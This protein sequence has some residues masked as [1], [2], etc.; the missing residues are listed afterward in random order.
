MKAFLYFYGDISIHNLI[1]L[2]SIMMDNKDKMPATP[3]SVWEIIRELSLSI[4]ESRAELAESSAKF[5]R[6]L[7][8]SSA[9]FDR[10]LAESHAKWNLEM[11]DLKEM[12]GGT[13]NSN[14]M[15]A[16]EYFFNSI[17]RGDK[18]LFGEKFD[19]CYSSLKRYNRN[20]RKKSEH[21]VLLVNGKSVAIVEIK[22]KARK[23]DI[24]KIINKIPDFRSLYPQYRSH[25]IYLGLAAM[26]FENGVEIESIN[27]GLAIIKQVGDTVVIHDEHLKTF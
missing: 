19:E 8:E 7:A 6:E 12:I 1:I 3:E 26:S 14:G 25:R 15:F 4:K 20:N 17:D 21:D 11:K 18:T 10:E 24:Q 22:Y 27:N 16:E 5:D 23:E 13:A 9:K 2:Q